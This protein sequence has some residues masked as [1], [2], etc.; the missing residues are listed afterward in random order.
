[1][2]ENTGQ[3]TPEFLHILQVLITPIIYFA[4]SYTLLLLAVYMNST[5]RTYE[6]A[7]RLSLPHY[8]TQES[9]GSVRK[10]RSSPSLYPVWCLLGT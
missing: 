5:F 2:P 7:Q 3:G 10:L 1:M 4:T 8:F 6:V 9:S